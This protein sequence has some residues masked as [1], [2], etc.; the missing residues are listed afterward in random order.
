MR[1]DRRRKL[2]HIFCPLILPEFAHLKFLKNNAIKAHLAYYDNNAQ[3]NLTRFKYLS[4]FSGLDDTAFRRNKGYWVYANSSG[5]L[6]LLSVGGSLS[7]QTYD[8]S[9]LRFSNSSG[10]ELNVTD[11]GAGGWLTTTL[12]Y[13]DGGTA[14]TWETICGSTTPPNP[15]DKTTISSW[16]GVFVYSNLDN[17]T[18][19][20]QN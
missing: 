1:N 3:D 8:W 6:S 12:Q 9:E 19:I 10:S 18:L 17:I 7:S 5:N 16:E 14:Y 20:R 4:T 13:T 15:C 2:L 11:A